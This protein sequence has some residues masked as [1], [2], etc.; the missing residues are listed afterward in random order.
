MPVVN[1]RKCSFEQVGADRAQV[2]LQQCGEGDLLLVGQIRGPLQEAEP[3]MLEHGLVVYRTGFSYHTESP[4]ELAAHIR[5]L[6]EHRDDARRMGEEA[7][8]HVAGYNVE[9]AAAGILAAMRA[10]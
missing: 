7:R 4:E 3:R 5:W 8:R 6:V 10:A 9:R 2:D 1:N